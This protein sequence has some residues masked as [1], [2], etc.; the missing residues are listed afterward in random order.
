MIRSLVGPE[1]GEDDDEEDLSLPPDSDEGKD[2]D[3]H[4]QDRLLAEVWG[5]SG[6]KPQRV[7][8][9]L[10]DQYRT[11]AACYELSGIGSSL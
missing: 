1:D 6:H 7:P 11:A 10:V 4:A 9:M 8:S 5:R 3:F 2:G